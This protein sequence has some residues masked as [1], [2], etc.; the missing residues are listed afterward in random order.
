[1]SKLGW[2]EDAGA[3]DSFPIVPLHEVPRLSKRLLA[4]CLSELRHLL[5][6]LASGAVRG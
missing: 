6:S 3:F 5:A 1:M 2:I 4:R